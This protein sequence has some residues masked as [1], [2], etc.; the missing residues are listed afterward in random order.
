[1]AK[2][3]S[4]AL[5]NTLHLG[6]L[7]PFPLRKGKMPNFTTPCTDSSTARIADYGARAMT[8]AWSRPHVCPVGKRKHLARRL[9]ATRQSTPCAPFCGSLQGR[10]FIFGALCPSKSGLMSKHIVKHIA[11]LSDVDSCSL[12]SR[13]NVSFLVS[14]A[15]LSPD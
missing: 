13:P 2:T 14:C 7:P 8:Y 6:G 12:N 1:M 3:P 5:A 9:I 11:P 15:R 10:C 4:A